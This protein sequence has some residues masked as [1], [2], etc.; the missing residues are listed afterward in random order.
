MKIIL[1]FFCAVTMC[2]VMTGVAGT[3]PIDLNI[4]G[5]NS[6]IKLSEQTI[7][8]DHA[9]SSNINLEDVFNPFSISEP[10]TTML[11]GLGLIGLAGFGR[12][13]LS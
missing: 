11:M 8:L 3:I 1:V 9:G 12:R 7:T 2:L 4:D 10:A 5:P 13:K 6:S